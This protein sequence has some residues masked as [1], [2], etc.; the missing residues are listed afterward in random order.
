MVMK[1]KIL[2]KEVKKEN[3]ENWE[4]R[5][6]FK[7]YAEELNRFLTTT[8]DSAG[9]TI[10]SPKKRW[11]AYK[12]PILNTKSLMFKL[13]PLLGPKEKKLYQKLSELISILEDEAVFPS[14]GMEV[15]K[16]KKPILSPEDWSL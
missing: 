1:I 4:A 9:D 2:L 12:T 7:R 8:H 5:I 13:L 10:D 6:S 14:M 3:P 11:E 15:P 16:R